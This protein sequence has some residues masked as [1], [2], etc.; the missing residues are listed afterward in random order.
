LLFPSPGDGTLST[1]SLTSSLCTDEMSSNWKET[2]SS[3]Q[4]SVVSWYGNSFC[5]FKNNNPNCNW[6]N[7]KL[8]SLHTVVV[9]ESSDVE[10]EPGMG[11][12]NLILGAALYVSEV[13][14]E[15]GMGK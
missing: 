15:P 10:A 7:T 6:A 1:A 2:S 11:K 12:W 3:S 9:V 5:I 4:S 8:V 13:G 14:A